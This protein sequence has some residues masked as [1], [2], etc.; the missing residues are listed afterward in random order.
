MS[1][2][3]SP[4]ERQANFTSFEQSNPTTP[5]PGSS[6]DAEF[7]ALRVLVNALLNR[8]AE[9]QRDDGQLRNG[10]VRPAAL[11]TETLTLIG[12]NLTP[13]GDWTTDEVYSLRDVV[14][15][16]GVTYVCLVEHM[17]GTFTTDL[18]AGK[19]QA[20]TS[21]PDAV[22]IP[23]SPAG[24]LL[25]SDVQNAITELAGVVSNKQTLNNNLSALAGLTLAA[26]KLPYATGA[27]ALALADLTAFGRALAA[28]GNPAGGRTV[29]ELG[30]AALLGTGSTNGL[31]PLVGAGDKLA[32]ALIP[33]ITA[34]MLA[35]TL[36]LS[37]K[38]VSL[39][40]TAQKVRQV[41]HTQ[42]G[43]VATGTAVIPFD[44]TIPQNTEGVEYMT[45]A[46]TPTNAASTLKIE[47]VFNF[48]VSALAQVAVALFQDST[49][50]ALAAM[51]GSRVEAAGVQ[52]ICV[53][54]HYMTAGTT[55]ATTFKVR[56]GSSTGTLTFN[57]SAGA[58]RFGGVMASSITITEYAP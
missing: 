24:G 21:A 29:L 4:Y 16:L 2:A 42:E 55:S 18:A 5:K 17:S 20:L 12:S 34:T 25:S 37:S 13:R 39:P 52:A 38:T 41:V 27:G 7:N 45:L 30:A 50:A 40:A 3:P 51:T 14:D 28:A 11:S 44:D 48:A 19:W 33:E 23:F 15:R 54:T 1:T 47:V 43:D 49:A 56:A 35:A 36:D 10:A 8:L 9:I 31:I 32:A 22:N 6:L 46:I 26:D 57:G 58:R 53:F